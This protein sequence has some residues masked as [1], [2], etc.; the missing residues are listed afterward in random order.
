MSSVGSFNKT[1]QSGQ[2]SATT[3]TLGTNVQEYGKLQTNTI[4]KKEVTDTIDFNMMVEENKN[5]QTTLDQIRDTANKVW[6]SGFI[7]GCNTYTSFLL[8]ANDGAFKLTERIG[9]GFLWTSK[10]LGRVYAKPVGKVIS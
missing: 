7:K 4:E 6:N 2:V 10:T 9:D 8:S 5:T 1:A 3:I